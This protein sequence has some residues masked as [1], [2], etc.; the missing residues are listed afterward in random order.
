MFGKKIFSICA[1]AFISMNLY[2]SELT[3]YLN[4]LHTFK[5]QFTQSVFTSSKNFPLVFI[6]GYNTFI[7]H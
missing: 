5:A 7:R 1:L 6:R 4:N 2:A 3:E